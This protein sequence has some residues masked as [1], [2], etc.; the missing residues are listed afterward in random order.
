MLL[1]YIK[2]IPCHFKTP[3]R[4]YAFIQ[5]YTYLKRIIKT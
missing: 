5:V 2:N 3:N 1:K 4:V